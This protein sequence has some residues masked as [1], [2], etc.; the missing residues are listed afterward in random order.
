MEN[1]AQDCASAMARKSLSQGTSCRRECRHH[2]P[3]KMH[4]QRTKRT[5]KSHTTAFHIRMSD[6][7]D[8]CRSMCRDMRM[9]RTLTPEIRTYLT[10]LCRCIL[11]AHTHP[12]ASFPRVG[13]RDA[14]FCA[15]GQS[16]GTAN[17]Q[18]CY[19]CPLRVLLFLPSYAKNPACSGP[20]P[21]RQL[22]LG[23]LSL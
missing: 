5:K 4:I 15:R 1:S 10:T 17:V 8:A 11:H 14:H 18:G 7:T 13:R 6:V 16:Y 2:V 9:C 23:H 20:F 12:N 19:R 21:L 22:F 3:T